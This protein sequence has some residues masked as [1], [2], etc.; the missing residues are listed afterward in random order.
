MASSPARRK[1]TLSSELSW[2]QFRLAGV[3]DESAVA[4]ALL[5]I[6]RLVAGYNDRST[7]IVAD[8]DKEETW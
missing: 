1:P 6:N 3:S 2:K 4:F 7:G 5:G 8:L